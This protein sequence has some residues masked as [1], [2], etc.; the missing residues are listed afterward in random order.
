MV[1][2]QNPCTCL[3]T[4]QTSGAGC[5]VV[6]KEALR[7]PQN[8]RTASILELTLHRRGNFQIRSHTAGVTLPLSVQQFVQ[9]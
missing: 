2:R 9:L 4:G 6:Q 3:R 1:F 7:Y 5:H 8:F